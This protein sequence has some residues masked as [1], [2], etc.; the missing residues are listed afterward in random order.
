MQGQSSHASGDSRSRRVGVDEPAALPWYRRLMKRRITGR[1]IATYAAVAAIVYFSEPWAPT[2]ALGCVFLLLAGALRIWTYG[3]LSKNES[4]VTSGP[5]AHTRNPA[6]LGS[7]LALIGFGLAVGNPF[8]IGG[9]IAWGL[10]LASLVV[11]VAYYLPRKYT[12]EYAR[13]RELF[14]ED[15]ANHAANVPDLVPRIRPWHGGSQRRFL[16]QRVRRNHET[17]WP[18]AGGSTIATVLAL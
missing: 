6:Y 17:F 11:F 10:S 15:Y 18:A 5:F 12:R 1:K 3:H 14:P 9:H 2:F 13:L 4:L 7:L 16:W 8:T